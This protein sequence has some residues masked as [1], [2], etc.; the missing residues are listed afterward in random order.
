[1]NSEFD[2]EARRP[3]SPSPADA[4]ARWPEPVCSEATP[5]VVTY[6][7]EAQKSQAFFFRP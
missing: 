5:G 4:P 6:T 3:S 7:F 2:A 1:M